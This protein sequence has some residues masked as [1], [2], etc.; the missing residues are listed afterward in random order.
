MFPVIL[1]LV[2]R[3]SL[4]CF[5]HLMGVFA[6]FNGGTAVGK[7]IQQLIGKLVCHGCF[8]TLLGCGN[9]PTDCQSLTAVSPYLARNL[10]R[11]TAD[12]A[13]ADFQNRFNIF[14]SFMEYYTC[15]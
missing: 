12:A 13:G 2:M 7:G 10:V 9:N 15:P 4:V 1:E 8:R 3:E 11:G 14:N 5:S 6:L